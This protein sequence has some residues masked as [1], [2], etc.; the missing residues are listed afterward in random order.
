[1]S[2]TESTP[3]PTEEL[4]RGLDAAAAQGRNFLRA[5]FHTCAAEMGAFF[6]ELAK[7]DAKAA[8]EIIACRTPLEL[9]AVEQRWLAA[10]AEAFATASMR[11]V[12]GA[13][14]ESE[15]AAAETGAWRLPD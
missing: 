12:L 10:R 4:M 14:H 6:Q 15:A 3:L 7:D 2:Q 5:S 9:L 11:M 1:M 13:M 8:S